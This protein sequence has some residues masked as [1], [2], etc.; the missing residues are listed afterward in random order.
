MPL[1]KEIINDTLKREGKWSRTS[2][3]MVTAWACCLGTYLT[4]FII[5]GFRMDAFTVM[6]GCALGVKW[7]DAKSKQIEKS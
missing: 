5:E 2:L 1:F 3:T 6:V 7:V 4:D